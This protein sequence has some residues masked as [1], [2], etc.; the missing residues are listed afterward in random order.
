MKSP[1]GGTIALFIG[2]AIVVILIIAT[3]KIHSSYPY[4]LL[5]RSQDKVAQV[6]VVIPKHITQTYVYLIRPMLVELPDGDIKIKYKIRIHNKYIT[7][8]NG[9]I[10]IHPTLTKIYGEEMIIPL[11]NIKAIVKGD[12]KFKE[13]LLE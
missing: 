1:K 8:G 5:R 11:C 10:H 6:K 7:V 3:L 9:R 4:S 13:H 2:L 12:N